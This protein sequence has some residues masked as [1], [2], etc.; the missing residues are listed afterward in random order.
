MAEPILQ[1]ALDM[2]YLDRAVNIAKEGVDGGVDWVEAGTPLIK[3]AGMDAV[4]K[5]RKTFP[6]RSIV[7]DMKTVDAGAPEIEMASNAGADVV[8]ILATAEDSTIHE[9]VKAGRRYGTKIMVDM[10]GVVDKEARARKLKDLG[11]DIICIHVGI[12]QQ[13]EGKSPLDEIELIAG[14]GDITIAAAGGL[15][16]ETAPDIIKRGA[17]IVIVGGAIT[18]AENVKEE[19][20]TIKKAMISGESLPTK[21]YKRYTGEDIAAAFM[22]ASTPNICDAMQKE[23]AMIGILPHIRK[24]RK[25]VGRAI[26]VR[27]IDGDWAK[28]IEAIDMAGPGDV[29]VIDVKGGETAVWGE[30]ASW[31]CKQKAI[32][33]VVIDGAARDIPDILAMDFPV[34][35]RHV[36]PKAGDPKGYGEIGIEVTC[37]GECVRPGDWIVGDETGVVVIPQNRAVEIANRSLDVL[38]RENRLRE[39]IKGGSTLSKVMELEKWEK[40]N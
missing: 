30:L 25:M 35:S 34:F 31:S 5:L 4:R 17:S 10:L 36:N 13:M 1:L 7:A 24:C 32:E 23:G 11:V 27:T 20:A 33:G 29:I 2:I 38:E 28:P 37:G 40:L 12:D 22:K 9:A 15:N 6:D 19:A 26:T 39:E 16:S 8:V 18:K 21:H 3:S 14:L